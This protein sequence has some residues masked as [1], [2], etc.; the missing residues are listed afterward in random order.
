MKRR[1]RGVTLIEM[2]VCGSVF[3][4]LALLVGGLSD[5]SV[6]MWARGQ[7]GSEAQ[8]VMAVAVGRIEPTIMGARRIDTD[9]SG[10]RSLTVVLPRVGAGG[11][12]VLPPEDGDRVTFY[13]ANKGGHRE[14]DGTILWRSINGAPDRRWAM[15]HGQPVTNLG[16][17]GLRFTY[18]A[19]HTV[20]VTIAT[21]QWAGSK[22]VG[23]DVSSTLFLRNHQ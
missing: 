19:P 20:A 2:L 10:E 11:Q 1:S 18:P 5:S 7:A 15:R 21:E 6:K 4:A 3:L 8:Q 17:T 13:L 16:T 14:E 9:A 22:S 12:V 23:R